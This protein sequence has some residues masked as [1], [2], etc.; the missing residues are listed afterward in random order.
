MSTSLLSGD[1]GKSVRMSVLSLL[2]HLL[3]ASSNDISELFINERLT[4]LLAEDFCF[5]DA[6]RHF[7]AAWL[8]LVWSF[9]PVPGTAWLGFVL[10]GSA[11]LGLVETPRRQRQAHS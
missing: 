5:L 9:F 2:F 11:W 3:S 10:L 1:M 4:R 7:G 6:A 8:G